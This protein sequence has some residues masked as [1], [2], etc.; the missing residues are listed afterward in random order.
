MFRA[1]L[2]I[3]LLVAAPVLAQPGPLST[4]PGAPTPETPAQARCR[5]LL[6]AEM[7]SRPGVEALGDGGCRFTHARIGHG[8][9]DLLG[10]P[11]FGPAFRGYEAE[12]VTEHGLPAR[13]DPLPGGPVAVQLEARNIR[14]VFHTDSPQVN[15]LF[16]QQ[17]FP[18]DITFNAAFDPG[19]RE[20]TLHRLS[21]DGVSI[22]HV[23]LT[24]VVAGVTR[25]DLFAGAGLQSVQVHLDSRRFIPAFVLMSVATHLPSNDPGV[26]A[27]RTR[28]QVIAA[29]RSLLPLAHASTGS[30]DPLVAFA[31][32]FPRPQ[33]VLDLSVTADPPVPAETVLDVLNDPTK[34]TSLIG[35]LT[36]AATYAGEPH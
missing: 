13:W 6:P 25:S 34:V 8:L 23:Q 19:T 18:F 10:L 5:D 2:A 31:Q 4:G 35:T 24:A 7:E 3:L 17:Q 36:I 32:D 20:L 29:L 12:T 15:W 28:V 16:E 26:A 11:N 14:L 30:V 1:T 33:H 21:M 22:G 27:E 9:Y